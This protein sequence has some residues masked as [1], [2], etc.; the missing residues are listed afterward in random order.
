MKITKIIAF[1]IE[2]CSAGSKYPK[3]TDLVLGISVHITSSLKLNSKH[4]NK[5]FIVS[6]L[7]YEAE[8]EIIS[9]FLDFLKEHK[10]A[11]LT[12]YNLFG[13]D[14]PLLLA[15]SKE[16][17]PLSFRLL[18]VIS[19]F[20][21]YD[22]MIAY[23]AYMGSSKSC[24]L[25]QALMQLKDQGH[26]CFVLDSKTALSGKESLTFWAKEAVGL[27]KDFSKYIAEDSYNHMRLAQFLLKSNA[28]QGFWSTV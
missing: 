9:K 2:S 13:F 10:T 26:N 23:K 6:E 14:Q 21:L 4:Q 16:H 5:Q 1:D 19:N 3:F 28:T 11:V 17:Y 20:D 22:T 7:T 27:S 12:S 24:K 8:E 25:L 15:R 18:D